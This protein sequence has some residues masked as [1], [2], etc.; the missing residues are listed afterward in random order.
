M[1]KK[2]QSPAAPT[3]PLEVA[4][5]TPAD[6]KTHFLKVEMKR[7]SDEWDGM[8]EE[9]RVKEFKRQCKVYITDF[10]LDCDD[11]AQL[12][13]LCQL[14]DRMTGGNNNG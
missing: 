6:M 14:I 8:T 12:H 3:A 1:A 2:V 5:V 11:T 4:E 7:S 13:T 10:T 9:E